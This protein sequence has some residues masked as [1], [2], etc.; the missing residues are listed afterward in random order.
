VPGQAHSATAD[1]LRALGVVK[2]M[3]AQQR[4]K[5][6]EQPQPAY[7]ETVTEH[8]LPPAIVEHIAPDI[9]MWQPGDE[10][11]PPPP[12]IR[13]EFDNGETN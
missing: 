4:E 2:A 1:A 9:K 6:S 11:P 13:V 12:P 8:P 7:T 3:A 5:L 10:L